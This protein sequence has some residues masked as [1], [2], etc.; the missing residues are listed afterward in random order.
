VSWANP[1]PQLSSSR[2]SLSGGTRRVARGRRGRT[3]PSA[4]GLAV[5]AAGSFGAMALAAAS[6]ATVREPLPSLPTEPRPITEYVSILLPVHNRQFHVAACLRSLLAQRLLSRSEIVVID[7]GSTDG[8]REVVR[9][10]IED[11]PRVRLLSAGE[12]P[13][14]WTGHSSVCRQLAV[15]AR[16][17]VYVYVDA[18]MRL[19]PHA[20]AATVTLL[21]DSGL[22]L[23]APVPADVPAP[24]VAPGAALDAARR[25]LVAIDAATYWRCGGHLGTARPVPDD[26]ALVRAVRRA[27]GRGTLADGTGI[28]SWQPVSPLSSPRTGP[29]RGAPTC[30]PRPS[31]SRTR[32]GTAGEQPGGAGRGPAPARPLSDTARRILGAVSRALTHA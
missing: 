12:P 26:A 2:Q 24:S 25:R 30:Q 27:G 17:S 8:T 14:G 13:T 5:T 15:A 31:T 23:V 20:I 28:V 21:R 32:P 10:V 16:G 6:L 11:D 4:A 18:G 7:N 29:S 22:D 1:S 19:E 3:F 9:A